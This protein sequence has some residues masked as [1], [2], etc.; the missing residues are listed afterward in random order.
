M[1]AG[2]YVS[3]SSQADTE[4]AD[5]ARERKELADDPS[6]EL[7]ELTQ[8]YLERGLDEPLAKEV[9]RQLTASDALGTHA[10]DE[11]GISKVMSARPIQAALTSAATF[12]AGA[13]LPLLAAFLAPADQTIA[14][15]SIA[16]LVFLA[17]LGALGA[18]TGGAST[19]RGA[20]R[21][22]FWGAAAMAAT[23]IIGALFG[24]AVG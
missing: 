18:S 17:G 19:T 9:A 21:V 1:A 10:R 24:V 3:V 6:A 15:V 2:E 12:A 4:K 8:I 5:L 7:E 16:S 14:I 13:S 22:V 23:A 11:L 20:V